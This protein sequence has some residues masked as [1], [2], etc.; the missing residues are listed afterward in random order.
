MN[1]KYKEFRNLLFNELGI[2]KDDIKEWT[3]EAV[4]EVAE[5]F[6]EHQLKSWSADSFAER[7]VKDFVG[8]QAAFRRDIA[9]ALVK[10][11]ELEVKAK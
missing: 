2:T 7:S 9:E 11:L 5:N 4:K 6:V 10:Q 8:Y 1:S 3:K